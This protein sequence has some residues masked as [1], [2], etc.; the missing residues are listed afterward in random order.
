MYFWR[1]AGTDGVISAKV[2][3]TAKGR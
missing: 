1:L 3:K 2:M